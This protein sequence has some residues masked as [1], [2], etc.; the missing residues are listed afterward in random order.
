MRRRNF[1]SPEASSD[2]GAG[3]PA[4]SNSG[5]GRGRRP[6]STR[7]TQCREFSWRYTYAWSNDHSTLVLVRGIARFSFGGNGMGGAEIH[8]L[9]GHRLGMR[10]R[11][12]PRIAVRSPFDRS[13]VACEGLR[14]IIALP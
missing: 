14:R 13:R 6:G 10:A 1:G 7:R 2:D 12:L 9:G 4:C 8:H 11:A 3:S 5:N